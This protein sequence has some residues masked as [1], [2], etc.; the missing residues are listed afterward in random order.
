MAN[1]RALGKSLAEINSSQ[2]KAFV[3][4]TTT[5][6]TIPGIGAIYAAGIFAEIG[7]IRRFASDAPLARYAGLAWRKRQSGNF[8]FESEVQPEHGRDLS[9]GNC[10]P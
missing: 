7:D 5:L 3:G 1:I 10:A 6:T 8:T 4:F 9:E 2:E